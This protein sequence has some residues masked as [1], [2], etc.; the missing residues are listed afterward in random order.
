[1]TYE[2][3]NH[4]GVNILLL[5]FKGAKGNSFDTVM[6]K[7]IAN[8][9]EEHRENNKIAGIILTGE[10]KAFSVGG[11]VFAM[12]KAVEAND[13]SIYLEQIVPLIEKVITSLVAYPKPVIAAVNGAAAG[14][15]M[16]LALACDY[17]FAVENAKFGMG[18]GGIGLTSD[19]GSSVIFTRY[20]GPHET[21]VGVATA[22]LYTAEELSKRGIITAVSADNLLSAAI[23]HICS[24]ASG[25]LYSYGYTKILVNQPV[26]MQLQ[27]NLPLEYKFIKAAADRDEFREK[28]KVI[29]TK[30]S[31]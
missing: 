3:Q 22:K 6:L 28:V 21:A 8:V 24:I 19:S 15:G 10:G 13:P 30:L 12:Y 27:H 5:T 2:I 4:N 25:S 26:I 18:F 7:E 9:L 17:V 16:S 20:F 14:A 29:I 11:D 1:M 31:K 23:D